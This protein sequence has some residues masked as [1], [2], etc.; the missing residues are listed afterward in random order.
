MKLNYSSLFQL[1]LW[2]T[3]ICGN[4]YEILEIFVQ[5]G[6]PHEPLFYRLTS[7]AICQFQEALDAIETVWMFPKFTGKPGNKHIIAQLSRFYEDTGFLHIFLGNSKSIAQFFILC[8][9]FE[10]MAYFQNLCAD[11]LWKLNF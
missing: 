1:E 8:R 5:L 6:G 3:M 7:N 9:I 4:F 2:F 11:K 10:N